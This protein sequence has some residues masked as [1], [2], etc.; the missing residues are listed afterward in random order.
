M[1]EPDFIQSSNFLFVK[2]SKFVHISLD[3]ASFAYLK[4]L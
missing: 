2:C 1:F 4:N 3:N